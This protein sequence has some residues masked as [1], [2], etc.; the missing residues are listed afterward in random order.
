ML[1]DKFGRIAEKLRLSVT[2]RCNY[3][4]IF[5]MPNNP[6]F[7]REDDILSL[8]EIYRVFNIFKDLGINELKLTGGEPLLRPD[9]EKIVRYASQIFREVS[10]TTNGY[11]LKEKAKA[12]K[13]SG[14]KRI[15]VSLHSLKRDKYYKITGVDGL[16]K[17]LEGLSEAKILGFDEIKINVTLIRGLNEDEI[18]DFLDFSKRTGFT[19]RFLEYEPFDGNGGWSTSKVFT[20]AEVL[21]TI[22]TRYSI[23]RLDRS[24]HSTAEYYY[25]K[26]LD[27]KFGAISSISAPFCKDCNR[28]RVTANGEFLPCM[29]SVKGVNLKRLMREGKSDD[30]I[31][32]AIINSYKDKFEGVISLVRENK[33]P[34]NVMPMFKLGG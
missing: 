15:N 12:L 17:V 9:L 30:E 25:I 28:V 31:K 29:Y 10:L 6:E 23:K 34:N 11:Y 19:V 16:F 27:L 33:I 32:N 22:S 24:P 20:T 13:Q 3:R 18:F 2:D 1:L 21:K 5:C 7:Y 14:L 8:D 26:D 4:C